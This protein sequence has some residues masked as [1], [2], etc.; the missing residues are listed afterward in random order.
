M[1]FDRCKMMHTGLAGVRVTPKTIEGNDLFMT[2]TLSKA[3]RAAEAEEVK[4]RLVKPKAP[5]QR[6][7]DIQQI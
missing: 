3:Q 1:T 7:T 4:D 5:A 6:T 2:A